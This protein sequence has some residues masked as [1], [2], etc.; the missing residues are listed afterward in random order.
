MCRCFWQGCAVEIRIWEKFMIAGVGVGRTFYK[1]LFAIKVSNF[2]Q[3]F[4][5][6]YK[7]QKYAENDRKLCRTPTAASL[8]RLSSTLGTIKTDLRESVKEDLTK[9]I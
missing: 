1:I 9:A 5:K 3:F 2:F 8:Q 7:N 4:N 6:F